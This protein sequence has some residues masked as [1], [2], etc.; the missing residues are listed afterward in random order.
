MYMK[1]SKRNVVWMVL[2]FVMVVLI[3]CTNEEEESSQ[4]IEIEDQAE[5]LEID[6]DEPITIFYESNGV[7]LNFSNVYPNV[8]FNAYQMASSTEANEKDC[9]KYCIEKYGDPDIILINS[10]LTD[11]ISSNR[12]ERWYQEGLIA[13]LEGMYAEDDDLEVSDYIP[14]TFEILYNEEVLLGIP[15]S[16]SMQG[17]IVPE[18][19][20]SESHLSLLQNEFN[21]EEL[22]NALLKEL[23][24]RKYNDKL[25]WA[26]WELPFDPISLL[27]DMGAIIKTENDEYIVDE[28]LFASLYEFCM[29]VRSLEE[30]YR[31]MNDID[32][33]KYQGK[34][35]LDPTMYDG[36]YFGLSI[37]G[38][39]QVS[40]IYAKSIANHFGNTIKMYWIPSAND[41]T[42]YI[43]KVQE[44]ALLGGN[45]LRKAQAYEVIRMMMDMPVNI[46]NQ[47]GP[48]AH[49]PNT[50]SPVNIQEAINM[51]E[52]FDALD[53]QN[54]I[55]R[56][57]SEEVYYT[58]EKQ[59]LSEDEKQKIIE[60]IENMVDLDFDLD[61]QVKVT[62]I[63]SIYNYYV[64]EYVKDYKHCY[65]EIMRV[66]NPESE[67][68]NM[69]P[70]EV[71]DYM[72]TE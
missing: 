49:N 21:G 20:V 36:E 45:S 41:G 19:N 2:F 71:E 61:L 15:L 56:D 9:L 44:I 63:S 52:Y 47:P 25:F 23:E 26:D 24:S 6:W 30:Q 54:L 46:I 68:W 16:W 29:L 55:I 53:V 66:L 34:L 43:G 7:L 67:K 39:P 31:N 40:M 10:A 50:F 69:T 51:L 57:W 64:G 33:S 27:I 17:L 42:K 8:K 58:I 12:I 3:S 38:A 62:E 70:E 14:G 60:M 35:A 18:S 37:L 11:D 13:D 22:F 32:F 59:K 1:K 4:K 5:Q 72:S 48:T 28:K 65:L